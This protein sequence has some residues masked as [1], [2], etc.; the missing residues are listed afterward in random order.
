MKIV[1][2][3]SRCTKRCKKP[4][5]AIHIAIGIC[6]Q[7]LLLSINGLNRTPWPGTNSVTQIT[8]AVKLPE[9]W[10]SLGIFILVNCNPERAS[11]RR[12][13]VNSLP[14]SNEWSFKRTFRHGKGEV[15][16]VCCSQGKG[17]GMQHPQQSVV[18]RPA[19]ILWV[20]L[21]RVTLANNKNRFSW[22]LSWTAA[23]DAWL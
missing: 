15:C 21:C 22:S 20:C 6:L 16:S 1:F 12:Q 9:N 14:S 5:H 18:Q 8:A 13:A 3:L 4:I 2:H 19:G 7:G 23:A 10:R 11:V 17:E